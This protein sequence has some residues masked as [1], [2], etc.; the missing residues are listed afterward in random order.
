MD[1]TGWLNRAA[2]TLAEAVETTT[3][4]GAP[5]GGPPQ[6]QASGGD[7]LL[8]MLTLFIPLGLVFYLLVWRPESKRRKEREQILNAVKVRDKVVT[9]GGVYGTV[10]EIEKDEIV[11][12]VDPRKDVRLRVRR[13]AVDQVEQSASDEKK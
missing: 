5:P 8:Q 1:Y 3:P 7:M 10:L 13:S 12:Q 4:P 11:M 2:L 6:R 9:I